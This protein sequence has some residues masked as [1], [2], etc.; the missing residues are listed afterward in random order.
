MEAAT[1]RSDKAPELKRE[2]K[3]NEQ[4]L[5]RL[6]DVDRK[7]RHRLKVAKK[8]EKDLETELKNMPVGV[9]L[10]S[11]S[12]TLE[13]MKSGKKW[14]ISCYPQLFNPSDWTQWKDQVVPEICCFS[15]GLISPDIEDSL[16]ITGVPT[17]RA[18]KKQYLQ[19]LSD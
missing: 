1:K 19:E 13:L 3:A 17:M 8:K 10:K 11:K 6:Q 14:H 15:R 9:V 7:I 5:K 16:E 18:Q 2:L 4:E 12:K